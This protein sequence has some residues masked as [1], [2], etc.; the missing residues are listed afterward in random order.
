MLAKD[1]EGEIVRN[2]N[3]LVLP[4]NTTVAQAARQMESQRVSAVL[5][6]EDDAEIVVG[7]FTGRDAVARVLARGRDPVKTPLA[8]VMTY[9]PVAVTPDDSA[10]K[11]LRLMQSAHCRHLPIVDE[12]RVV[13]L[14]S[15]GDFRSVDLE[16]LDD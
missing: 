14:I 3:P 11:A 2:P 8:D 16:C 1:A 12:G 10:M 5:V 9:N 13:G 6:V 4:S 7:I 15:R